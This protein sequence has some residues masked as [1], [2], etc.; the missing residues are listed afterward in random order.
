MDVRLK[1]EYMAKAQKARR[2]AAIGLV[3]CLALGGVRAGSKRR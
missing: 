3:T 2:S 1:K